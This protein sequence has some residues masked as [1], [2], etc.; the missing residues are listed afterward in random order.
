MI[1]VAV[2]TYNRALLAIK[3]IESALAQLPEGGEIVVIDQSTKDARVLEEFC[4]DHASAGVL[5]YFHLR[6]IGLTNARNAALAQAQR[7]YIFYLD[8]DAVPVPGALASHLEEIRKPGVAGSSGPIYDY[9]IIPPPND[10]KVGRITSAG[11]HIQNRDGNR[12]QTVETLFGG[13]MVFKT[14]LL[15]EVGGFET[16]FQ[17]LATWEETDCSFRLAR[18]GYDLTY[19]PIAGVLHYPQ[20][21]GNALSASQGR[22]LEYY[23]SYVRN[24]TC[25]F[26][27]GRPKWQQV[28]FVVRHILMCEKKSTLGLRRPG[29]GLAAFLRGYAQGW[30]LF[31]R[32]G[33][34][35]PFECRTT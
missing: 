27:R 35:P 12:Y 15:M 17:G 11:R 20:A 33:A 23:V 4:R 8:D 7:E 13:N 6:H 9:G 18:R 5:R 16:G 22:N 21:T 1:T 31:R 24:G 2:C 34:F 19:N 29:L 10:G 14:A 30:S 28:P 32:K 26:L 25:A 3:A